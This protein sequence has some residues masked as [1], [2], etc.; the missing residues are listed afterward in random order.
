MGGLKGIRRNKEDDRFL[1]SSSLWY[2]MMVKKRI[3][4]AICLVI[5]FLAAFLHP[6]AQEDQ[7]IEEFILQL[8][9]SLESRDMDSYLSAF[10]PGVREQQKTSLAQY[11]DILQM[12][13]V[14]ARWANKSVKRSP[15]PKVYLQV[16]FQ[17]PYSAIIETWQLSLSRVDGGWTI[18]EKTTR[19]NLSQLYKVQIPSERLEKVKSITIRHIDIELTFRDAL[20][21]YDNI[22]AQET[23]LLILGDGA[24][25][26]SPSDSA[27]K[28][29]LEILYKSPVLQDKLEY[30]FL[31]ISNSFFERNVTIEEDTQADS[32]EV[33]QTHINQAYSLFSKH[34]LRYF[35]IENS[36]TGEILSF[37]PQ[38]DEAVFQVKGKR[39]GEVV[40]IYSP[41]AR[42]EISFFDHEKERY[43]SLY[44][45][46]EKNETKRMFITFGERLD[47]RDYQIELDYVP[48][49]SYLS[50]KAKIEIAAQ[51]ET[52]DVVKF[53]FNPAFEILRI[54]DEE[55]RELF[56]TQDPR[57]KLLYVYF[58]DPVPRGQSAVVEILYRGKLKPPDQLT[59]VLSG[60]Q[61]SEI[62]V[63]F[64]PKYQTY[65]FSQTALWYPS[66]S[67]EDYFTARIK[68]IIPP[69][70][71][72]ISNG[73][74]IE[75]GKLNGVPEVTEI[76]KMGSSFFIFES[77]KPVKYLSFLVGRLNLVQQKQGSPHLYSY[78]SSDVRFPRDELL[79]T[80]EDILHFYE[81]RFGSFPFECLRII[82]RSWPTGGGHSPSS[83]IIIN[84]IPRNTEGGY[85]PSST[86]DPNS[87]VDLSQWREYFLAHEI[88]HQWWGQ[89]VT[90][91]RYRDL[92]LSEGL[93]QYS[94]VLYLKSKYNDRAFSNILRKL[95]K[96]VE[97]KSDWG[98]ISLGSRLSFLDFKAYQAIIYNKTALILN[99][100]SD[101]LGEEVFFAGLREF[102]NSH[103]YGA[104]TT[105]QF[106][107]T[108]EEV[109]GR[110]LDEFFAL[111][112]HSHLLPAVQVSTSVE[113]SAE[114]FV[115]KIKID[116]EK[117]VFIFPLWLEW[118]EGNNEVSRKVIVTKRSQEF[119]I[120]VQVRPK[121][122]KIN[123]SSAVPGK[124]H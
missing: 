8:E 104:A 97:R 123:P 1:G 16:I 6:S 117:E 64:S 57:G 45:P 71:S 35:T 68:I 19:G 108:M 110:D 80:A 106:K 74:L 72:A 103:K 87:P 18:T 25:T 24:L 91:G 70:Y 85:F 43:I 93:A 107:K 32:F 96:W 75:Q 42:E 115:L 36:L 101:L 121:R 99:M 44:S 50:A 49:N 88:A 66:P 111:W 120:P 40:Y 47:V 60:G 53:R 58:L 38:G 12:E 7:T 55:R 63:F 84:E 62:R 52:L 41:F 5:L 17:N 76:D 56:F 37:I 119:E 109:S 105:A 83:F 118:Q 4:P 54:Y 122:I 114:D 20:L 95:S 94:S 46:G 30:A 22:P 26:F 10:S 48:Q 81:S 124:F 21:F 34:Y 82:Q 27:E 14:T 23:A 77:K 51:V 67:D 61:Q 89:G 29:Q 92:W 15:E 116:Q 28:H 9:R 112:F 113:K 79:D 39:I 13:T 31:R 100:L 65:L 33:E 69:G 78:H 98:P 3:F 73:L 102:Y 11:F 90:W 59:D 2:N 86:I